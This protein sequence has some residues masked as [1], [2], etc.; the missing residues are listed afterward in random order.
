MNPGFWMLAW[1]SITAMQTHAMMRP[2]GW[3]PDWVFMV[4]EFTLLGAAA[5]EVGEVESARPVRGT[6]QARIAAA[7]VLTVYW[8]WAVFICLQRATA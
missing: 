1:A 6:R 5:F 8:A 3:V 7:S 2:T 4:M